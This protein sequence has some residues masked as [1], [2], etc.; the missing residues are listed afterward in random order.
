[1]QVMPPTG[2]WVADRIGSADYPADRLDRPY[3]SVRFGVHYLASVLDFAGGDLMMAL[4]GY[5]GGP[6]NAA[7][8]RRRSGPDDDVFVATIGAFESRIYVRSVMSQCAIY[9][10]LYTD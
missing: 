5:N 3:V 6:G 1:M 8:W 4:A 10:W 7:A 2:E 9:R